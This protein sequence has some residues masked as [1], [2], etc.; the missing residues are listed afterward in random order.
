MRFPA[1]SPCST[2]VIGEGLETVLS[3]ITAYPGAAGAAALAAAGVGSF[4]ASAS[5]RVAIARDNDPDG[6]QAAARLAERCEKSGIVCRVLIPRGND[7]NDDLAGYGIRSLRWHLG[8]PW[9]H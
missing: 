3:I 6:I 2:L 7:F 8:S 1:R 4:P 5:S 9:S